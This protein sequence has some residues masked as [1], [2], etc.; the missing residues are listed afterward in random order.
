M[1][2][3]VFFGTGTQS[4]RPTTFPDHIAQL[5]YIGIALDHLHILLSKLN[6]IWKQL[7]QIARHALND[8][9]AGSQ[10]EEFG[11]FDNRISV[12]ITRIRDEWEDIQYG[13]ASPLC[14]SASRLIAGNDT[15]SFRPAQTSDH[16]ERGIIR[17]KGG[18][19]QD[20][21]CP[22]CP[23]EVRFYVSSKNT[24]LEAAKFPWR[25]E[26]DAIKI[27]WR[28][29]WAAKSHLAR[30]SVA[31]YGCLLCL[32]EGRELIN[33]R[34]AFHTN[35]GL[36]KHIGAEHNSTTLPRIFMQRLHVTKK[37]D[38]IAGSH[39]VFSKE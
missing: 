21:L 14:S 22:D 23:Q 8:D 37:S 36:A 17:Q 30:E 33:Q 12:Q 4:V 10:W 28:D 29:F 11:E 19:F 7:L 39:L 35:V 6:S 20:W 34:N 15:G 24:S 32:G 27:K 25:K 3:D 18:H 26:D 38:K 5:T 1:D 2:F 16:S 31:N 13:S 9:N